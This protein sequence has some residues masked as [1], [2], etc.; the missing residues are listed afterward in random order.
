MVLAVL[1]FLEL[2]IFFHFCKAFCALQGF[3]QSSTPTL[4]HQNVDHGKGREHICI[5]R[6][7]PS[8]RIY[9]NRVFL[10]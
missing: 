10:A 1:E 3:S 6:L 7:E 2:L 5:Y 4:Q 9:Y 8:L